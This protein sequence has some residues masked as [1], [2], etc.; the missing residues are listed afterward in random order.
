MSDSPRHE[1]IQ[2]LAELSEL[3]PE[4]R[5]GQLVA[6]LASLA[7]GATAEAVWDTED[8]ELRGAQATGA[9]S[10]TAASSRRLTN[11]E[12]VRNV[13]HVTSFRPDP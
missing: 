7:K 1:L 8:D 10:R 5:F 9:F 2:V 12:H 4:M 13:L 11:Y 3:C 6:N